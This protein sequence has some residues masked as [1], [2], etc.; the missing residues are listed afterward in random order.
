MSE[1]S[2]TKP[3]P[4]FGVSLLAGTVV[5]LLA[6]VFLFIL[7]ETPHR[8]HPSPMRALCMANLRQ[9][10]LALVVYASEH[11]DQYPSAGQWCD[12]LAAQHG[13]ETG[14]PTEGFRQ[15]YCCPKLSKDDW[16]YAMNPHAR[17][18]SDPNVVLV[19]ESD[20]GWNGFG[21][22]ESL[23]TG[24]HGSDGCNVLFVDGSV[25][26]VKA[27]ELAELKWMDESKINARRPPNDGE[28]E[29]WLENMIWYHRFSTEEVRGAT[30]LTEAEILAAQERFGIWPDS[31]PKRE[32]DEPLLVLPYPGGRHPRIG[33]LEGAIDPQRETKFS[34]FTPWDPNSY[35]VVDV[36][37]AIWSSLGLTYLAHTHVATIWTQ[38]G[39]ELPKLEWNRRADGTLDIERKLPN[40]IVFGVKV[41]PGTDAVRMEMWLR[42]GTDQTL[43][44]LRVQNCV[45]PKMATGFA[46]QTNENKVFT[47]PYVACRSEDGRRWIIT[48]WESCDRPWGN[49]D[50]P[51]FHSDP[52]FPDLE[53]G[54]EHHLAGWLSFYEGDNV[55]AEFA[56][57]EAIGWRLNQTSSK[58]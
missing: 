42:N 11:S 43:T 19:F 56:R 10:G 52:R 31:R 30:G 24:R 21:G 2:T 15:T 5:I 25:R 32:A 45:M 49:E 7:L 3:R 20:A 51:C 38:Q 55:E 8:R 9:L 40:G 1:K 22:P 13:R 14:K 18:G 47:N 36:P 35:V 23:V 29:Y 39:V 12:L 58:P 57:I 46:A 4:R 44:D 48:A 37:E 41:V 16:G 27:D 17:P 26:F 50:C 6:I 33:F 54:Q 34:V 28:L 53:P